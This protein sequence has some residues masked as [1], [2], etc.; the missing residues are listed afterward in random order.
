MKFKGHG[1]SLF[2]ILLIH[3]SMN[4]S[5]YIDQWNKII[6]GLLAN[7]PQIS[8][9]LSCNIAIQSDFIPEPY[10][11]D[12]DNCSFVIVNLN[13]GTGQCHSC[14]KQ[15]DIAGTLVNKV[16]TN[17][18]GNAVKNFPYLR[19][20][21]TAGLIDWDNSGGRRWWKGKER[22]IKHIIKMFEPSYNTE[23]AIPEKYYPFAM[24]MF[25]WHTMSWPSELNKKMKKN[26][27]YGPTIKNEVLEPLY[28]AI[29]KSKFKF[30][31]CVG[32]P[33]GNIIG[34]FP[35]F[36][37]KNKEPIQPIGSINRFYD[38]YFDDKGCYII[39]TWAP[40]GNTYPSEAFEKE[41]ELIYK[42]F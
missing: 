22:W 2:F 37:K 15:K 36:S 11:G 4:L 18:Y 39:N 42:S 10:M 8:N 12:P 7:P 5:S 19:N 41:E 27:I 29:Q 21:A 26:G 30:A 14:I 31:F 28:D 9:P 24:E 17:G 40:G 20:G 1:S 16:K 34:S 32:K 6:K 35:L 23:D 38:I 13:P 33:I 25:A 3:L